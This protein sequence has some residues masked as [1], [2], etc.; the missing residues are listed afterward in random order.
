MPR[1]LKPEVVQFI[2]SRM[3]Q[4]RCLWGTDGLPW[5]ESLDPV[6]RLGLKPEAK[7]KLLRDNALALFRLSD[8][9]AA[10][11]S[12]WVLLASASIAANIPPRRPRALR[13]GGASASLPNIVVGDPM[14]SVGGPRGS[15]ER[16]DYPSTR[17]AM[18]RARLV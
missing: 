11:F 16:R 12:G 4:D 6:E 2:G 7:R 9:A 17:H 10:I 3:G 5:K 15:R 14:A 8:I 13:P 18:T 1:S